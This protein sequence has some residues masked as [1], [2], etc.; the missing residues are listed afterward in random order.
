MRKHQLGG[1]SGRWCGCDCQF[2]GESIAGENFFSLIAKRWTPARK[3]LILESRM[4]AGNAVLQAVRKLKSTQSSGTG[5][6]GWVLRQP[7]G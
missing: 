1:A 5:I 4:Q 2:G 3:Q 7:Q 6:G